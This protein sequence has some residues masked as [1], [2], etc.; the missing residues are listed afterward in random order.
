MNW[1]DHEEDLPDDDEELAKT[2]QDVID[3][4]GFDPLDTEFKRFRRSKARP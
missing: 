1:R 4:L 2:P 3:I